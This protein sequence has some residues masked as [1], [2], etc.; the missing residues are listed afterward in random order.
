MSVR[1]KNL[2]SE[3][4]TYEID[5]EMAARD[6]LF[7]MREYLNFLTEE[8]KI[9]KYPK[10]KMESESISL[11]LSP[12]GTKIEVEVNVTMKK[13]YLKMLTR[14]FLHKKG[15]K[16]WVSVKKGPRPNQ[17]VIFYYNLNQDDQ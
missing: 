3:K 16:D 9:T 12:S 2:P 7:D 5:C 4:R 8:N 17:Y 6:N 1:I 15:I 11:Q 14:K 10:S 13:K